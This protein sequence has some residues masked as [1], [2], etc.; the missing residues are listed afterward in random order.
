MDKKSKGGRPTKYKKEY[1]E[2]VYRLALLGLKDTEL[3]DYFDVAE[4]TLNLWKKNHKEFS[5]SLKEG[6]EIADDKVV[7]AL[8]NKACGYEENIQET[9]FDPKTGK[10]QTANRIKKHLPDTTAIIFW[11][12]NRQRKHWRDRI[13]GT[14]S[15]PDGGPIVIKRV[16]VDPKETNE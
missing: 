10:P 5:E 15:D 11:L 13:D 8:Y 14:L 2:Q 12:K 6:R 16:I 4:S 7:K 9:V 3:M 1:A